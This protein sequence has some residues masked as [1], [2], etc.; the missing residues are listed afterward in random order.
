MLSVTSFPG[1]MGSKK[2]ITIQG[3]HDFQPGHN[4]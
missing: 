4:S 2:G 1:A 3:D